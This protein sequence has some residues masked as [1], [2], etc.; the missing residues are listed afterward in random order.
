[1]SIGD[2][3]QDN[4]KRVHNRFLV[5]RKLA[6]G[7]AYC[8]IYGLYTREPQFYWRGRTRIRLDRLKPTHNGYKRR[9]DLDGKL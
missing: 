1:M 3:W 9:A 8:D 7:Y 2:V 4:D 6:I 5:I